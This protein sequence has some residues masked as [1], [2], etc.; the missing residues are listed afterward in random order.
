MMSL[1]A[2]KYMEPVFSSPLKSQQLITISTDMLQAV[3]DM[4][5]V[6]V[7]ILQAIRNNK[8]E[9]IDFRYTLVNKVAA[10]YS[11]PGETLFN[12]A[13]SPHK[14]YLETW[15]GVVETGIPV[16]YNEPCLRS[17][18]ARWFEVKCIKFGDGIV[19]TREN[20][21]TE[22]NNAFEKILIFPPLINGKRQDTDVNILPEV[23][24]LAEELTET[25][26]W[27]YDIITGRFNCSKGMYQLFGLTTSGI[28]S[29]EVYIDYTNGED[30]K[31][32]MD[33]VN[34]MKYEF[35]PFEEKMTIYPR[36]GGK[37]IILTRASVITDEKKNPV[38]MIGI[39]MNITGQM[40]AA[41]RIQ[42]M[43]QALLGKNNDLENLNAELRSLNS[44]AAKDYKGTLQVLYTN[45]EYIATN[46]AR[47]L[48]NTA[49]G[50]IR[51]AQSAIQKMKL[52]TDDINT[53]LELHETNVVLTPVDP[54]EIVR[55]VLSILQKKIGQYDVQIE[56]TQ[57]PV[58]PSHPKLLSLL[59]IKLIDNAIKYRKLVAAPLIKIKYSQA[60]EMNAIPGARKNIPYGIISV[61][62][63]G[64][65]FRESE[66]EKI[67]NLFYR[68]DDK[69]SYHG[70]GIGLSVCKKIMD[71]HG[72]FITAEGIPA[73][74]ATF[75][76]Y[77][78]LIH[79]S[80]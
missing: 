19:V 46:E 74:G 8:N 55:H 17:E 39:S 26:S 6:G 7:Q 44:V 60:D 31:V 41:V 16:S 25:G 24:K 9:I 69:S 48:S 40:E 61:S 23:L 5:P 14:N 1:G 75:T 66:A 36:T 3:L 15:I 53:Y 78:P 58:I 71:L 27:E 49:K 57:F 63:N 18:K 51:R 21:I 38:K 13:T 10:N 42:E 45:L 80:P 43:N 29:P 22:K 4:M 12:P 52:L 65:G 20:I 35:V 30:R 28:L 70:S 47:Y 64:I 68:V 59:L 54:N 32:A 62:D 33:L 73:N 56:A 34:R 11:E 77:F 50:N 2:I 76:C 67:F 79:Q 72:G 37:K